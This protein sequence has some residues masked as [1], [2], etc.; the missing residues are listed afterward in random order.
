MKLT[1]LQANALGKIVARH[2]S[3]DHSIG[4]DPGIAA[5]LSAK[6][7]ITIVGTQRVRLCDTNQYHRVTL[8][9]STQAGVELAIELKLGGQT[10]SI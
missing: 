1:K 6:G 5:R 10:L 8:V 2:I 9:A 7:L 4:I 3:G